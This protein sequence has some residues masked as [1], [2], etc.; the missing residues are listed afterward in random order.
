MFHR[1]LIFPFSLFGR[2]CNTQIAGTVNGFNKHGHCCRNPHDLHFGLHFSGTCTWVR[3]Q[4]EVE[5]LIDSRCESFQSDWRIVSG[6]SAV[7]CVFTLML[8]YF[9]PESPSWLISRGRTEEARK[10]LGYIR[11]IKS[12]GTIESR[13]SHFQINFHSNAS[14]TE[15]FSDASL[16]AEMD[17]MHEQIVSRTSAGADG[18]WET[19]KRPE[20]YKPLAIINAFFAFQQFSGTFVII[21]Y[22]TQFAMEAGAG[23]D[24]LLCTVLIG[25]SRVVATIILAYFILDKYGRKPPSIFSGIGKQRFG[26]CWCWCWCEFK[27]CDWNWLTSFFFSGMTISMLILSVYSAYG[28]HLPFRNWVTTS[29]LLVYIITSTFGF[30]TIPFTMLPELFPQRVRGLTAGISVCMAYFMSFIVI[31]SYPSMLAWMGNGTIFLFYGL[32]RYFKLFSLKS[33]YNL[34]FDPFSLLGT[35]F[36]HLFL[37]ETKGKSLQEIE[38]LFKSDSK[39]TKS[40]PARAGV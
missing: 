36:V 37:P 35:V 25:L 19:L 33:P 12:N 21:V 22:A 8:V 28:A 5:F 20:I 29:F 9:I 23:I 17:Q 16:N 2:N 1:N 4:M 40:R 18:L 24:K 39:D 27:C 6:I 10:A 7:F 15:L 30:L 13:F 32:V 26:S 34:S 3:R 14:L 11:A 31:K 38:H